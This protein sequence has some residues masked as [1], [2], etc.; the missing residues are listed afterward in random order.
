MQSCAAFTNVSQTAL[1][2]GLPWFSSCAWNGVRRFTHAVRS[3]EIEWTFHMMTMT[4]SVSSHGLL[5]CPG[6]QTTNARAFY[7]GASSVCSFFFISPAGA[8]SRQLWHHACTGRPPICLDRR[9]FRWPLK[10]KKKCYSSTSS[11]PFIIN[12]KENKH[13]PACLYWHALSET[14]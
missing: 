4:R 9:K 13:C 3:L 5:A 2:H 11:G 10:Y 8:Q 6:D 1:A 14:E 12:K 7:T